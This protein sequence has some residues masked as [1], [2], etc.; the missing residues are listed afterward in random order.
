LGFAPP[1]ATTATAT[2]FALGVRAGRERLAS[3]RD[4]DDSVVAN[5][6][7]FAL[8]QWNVLLATACESQR[9][10]GPTFW[11][12]QRNRLQSLTGELRRDFSA[13]MALM[14]HLQ[15]V[16]VSLEQLSQRYS[17]RAAF[18][19]GEELRLFRAQFL[20]DGERR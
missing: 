1:G 11:Q 4:A 19:L 2:S 17:R 14:A 10:L 16:D 5:E 8:G 12:N 7:F 9:P 13:D 6:E 15:R 18:E 3:G 20:A